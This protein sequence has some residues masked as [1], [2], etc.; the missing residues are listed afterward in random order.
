MAQVAGSGTRVSIRVNVIPSS[1]WLFQTALELFDP[2]E[3]KFVPE[4]KISTSID[5]TAR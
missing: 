1:P 2:R 5:G 4:S 3:A